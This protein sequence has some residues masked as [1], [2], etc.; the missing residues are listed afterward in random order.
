MK[1]NNNN[2]NKN[3]IFHIKEELSV[4]LTSSGKKYWITECIDMIA[5]H[6]KSELVIRTRSKYYNNGDIQDIL[7]S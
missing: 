3:D 7:F 6:I 5:V 4:V 1:T 2:S